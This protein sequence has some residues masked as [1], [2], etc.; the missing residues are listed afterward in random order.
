MERDLRKLAN[1]Y[2]GSIPFSKV[3]SMMNKSSKKSP[4]KV[5]KKTTKKMCQPLRSPRKLKDGVI[6]RGKD[7]KLWKTKKHK[8]IRIRGYS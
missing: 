7:N 1:Q 5:K 6:L 3:K 2:G 8:W 4:K